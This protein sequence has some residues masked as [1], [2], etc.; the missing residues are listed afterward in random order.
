[1]KTMEAIGLDICIFDS[2]LLSM[3]SKSI[4]NKMFTKCF[5]VA[6]HLSLKLPALVEKL[7]SLLFFIKP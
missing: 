1:M 7:F 2:Y 3:D 4:E 5:V 6:L